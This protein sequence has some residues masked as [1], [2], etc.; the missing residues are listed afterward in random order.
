MLKR[1]HAAGRQDAKDQVSGLFVCAP[2]ACAKSK[3]R[4]EYRRMRNAL[5]SQPHPAPSGDE[6]NIG[7][8]IIRIGFWGPLCYDYNKEPPK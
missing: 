4:V 3:K 5:Q 7:A 2:N 8:L 1:G 6:P